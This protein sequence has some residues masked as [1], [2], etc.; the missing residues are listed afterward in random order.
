MSFEYLCNDI[1]TIERQDGTRFKRVRAQVSA[2]SIIIPD[3]NIPIEPGDAVLRALP[4]GVVER[5]IVTEPG[6]HAPFHTIPAHY[7]IKYRREGTGPAG[8]PGYVIQ[9]SGENSRVN[10][11]SVD[12]SSNAVNSVSV[13]PAILSGELQKLREALLAYA[14]DVEHYAA[15]GHI[16]SA[17]LAAKAGDAS[18]ASKALSALGTAGKWVLDIAAGI[19]VPVAAEMLKRSLGV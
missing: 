17:E 4:S 13:D 12:N 18:K 11:N 2:K 8:T 9:V 14:R 10:V 5:F 3:S 6:F 19:G 16:A 15:I 1:V 7:Q